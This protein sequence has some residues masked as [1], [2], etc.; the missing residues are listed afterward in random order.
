M[1]A[2]YLRGS[3]FS[4]GE[5]IVLVTYGKRKGGEYPVLKPVSNP[6]GGH[7]KYINDFANSYYMFY[8][9]HH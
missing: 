4:V 6:A 1:K 3:R 2:V 5:G 7:K 8:K 9:P